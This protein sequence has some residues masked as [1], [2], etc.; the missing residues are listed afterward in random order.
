MSLHL[1]YGKLYTKFEHLWYHKSRL[2]VHLDMIGQYGV[3]T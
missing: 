2:K 3:Q 1:V